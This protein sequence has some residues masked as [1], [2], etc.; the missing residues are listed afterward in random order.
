M[1]DVWIGIIGSLVGSL[2]GLL[3]ILGGALY[4]AR[5]NRERDDRLRNEETRSVATALKAE[6]ASIKNMLDFQVSL[7]SRKSAIPLDIHASDISQALLIS[8]ALKD[9]FHLLDDNVIASLVHS[10]AAINQ[11]IV[12][13]LILSNYHADTLRVEDRTTV[14]VD[15]DNAPLFLTITKELSLN[16]EKT[17]EAL[18]CQIQGLPPPR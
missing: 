7:A 16:V 17:V 2:F 3:A 4:N 15:S 10:H 12:K 18:R 6:M 11:Y 5:L 1:N 9:R 14:R 8:D 13:L